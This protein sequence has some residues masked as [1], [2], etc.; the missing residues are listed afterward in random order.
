VTPAYITR[1]SLVSAVG[2]GTIA[3][4]A[5]LRASASGLR[6]NDFQQTALATF[7]GRV[8]GLET[9]GVAS[10]LEHYDCR[11]NR[12]AERALS[13][14]QFAEAA[15]KARTVY[16][17]ARVGVFVGT[18]SSGILETEIA[19]RN[20]DATTGSLPPGIRFEE[21]FNLFS[22]AAY[23]RDRLHLEGPAVSVSAA[24]ASSAK[25]FVSARRAMA[26]GLCD[27]AIVGGVET[28]CLTT[29]HGFSALGLLS[30]VPCR[31]C[32]A[33][34]DGISL[35]EAAGFAL[36]EPRDTAE[37]ALA[38]LGYGESSDAYHISTPHPEG[39]GAAIALRS[40]LS[41]ARIGAADIGYV[42]LHGTGTRTNDAA[43][44]IAVCAVLGPDVARSSTKGWTGHT[45][46]A[47]GIVEAVITLLALQDDYLPGT[48][49]TSVVDPAIRGN[50]LIAGC[51]RRI[52]HA[53]SNSFG[54]G[55]S[56]CS[57]VFGRAH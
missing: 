32:D 51:E 13:A 53:V 48:L 15:A 10:A 7:A 31:P 20:R 41:M 57:L 30:S 50:V 6:K 19:Y 26:A 22:A 14:D 33:E 36:L 17:A 9:D 34:R 47:A 35:G 55:G 21:T 12:L 29:M 52:A 54:F 23:V 18:T 40:A 37:T 24:C 25:A 1:C 27:A 2:D 8:A 49:N 38:L 39:A 56:N 43:E 3:T 44:D 4:L 16:G 5:A 45:L 46:G 28:L 11:N 42:N